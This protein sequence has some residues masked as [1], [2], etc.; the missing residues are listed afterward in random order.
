MTAGPGTDG[1]PIA[2]ALIDG[3]HYPP[4]VRDTLALLRAR[5]RIVG[6]VFLGGEEK[7]RDAASD[8]ELEA[9]YG[10]PLLRAPPSTPCCARRLRAS[11]LTC[12]TSRC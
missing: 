11:S 5:Y 1:S 9:L 6:A 2:V 8:D 3:E 4:V 12:P 10:L 7:L